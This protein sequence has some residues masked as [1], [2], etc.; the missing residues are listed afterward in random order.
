[1]TKRDF[2]YLS[3]DGK[4]QIHAVEWL[5]DDKPQ[6]VLQIAHGVTEH[7]LRYEELADFFTKKGFAVV[8]NDH[9]GHG[10]SV[11]AGAA[12][13]YCGPK[14]SWHWI[15]EDMYSCLK[16]TKRHFPNIPYI[17]LG[18][19]LGSFAIRSLLIHYPDAVDGAVLAGTGQNPGYQLA[20]V[21][22]LVENE[23][24]RVGEE[25]STPLIHKLSFGTY[26]RY[27]APNRTDFDWLCASREG[28]EDYI[29][30]ELR[31]K[32]LSAGL[33]R[34]MLSIMLF[35]GN[36]KNQKQMKKDVP[37]L[38]ISGDR[39]PVGNNGR[40]VKNTCQSFKKA[41]MK[42][43]TMKLFHG[44]RHD[45]FLED[46]RADVSDYIYQWISDNKIILT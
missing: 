5:P 19:S 10:Y 46:R 30:D 34:E 6:A 2:F 8:G 4:T 44:L 39:D 12:A 23:A 37:I 42:N 33:F 25:H 9:L 26:N 40:G 3:A 21:R 32:A 28:L 13:M 7:I 43:I 29:A 14:D 31:G 20:A 41:G 27:F 15:E 24:R 17:I 1:M 16:R 45:L 35:T 11:A 36:F 38:L 22:W 18:L